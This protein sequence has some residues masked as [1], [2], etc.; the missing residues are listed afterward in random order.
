MLPWFEQPDL[1]LYLAPMAGFTDTVYRQL[2]KQEGADV[3]VSEFVLA[4]SLVRGT[5]EAWEEVAFTGDQRPFG[6]QI[7]GSS[8]KVMA[9]ATV[10]LSRKLRPDF[11][12]L[13]F[14]CPSDK[15]TCKDAGSS[16]LRNPSKLARV[17]TQVVQA[18][19]QEGLPVT[20]K[21]RIGW[22][23]Q[24]IVAL[25]VARRLEDAGVEAVAIHGRTKEQGYRGQA[26]WD[27][28]QEVAEAL[29]IP[30]IGNGNVNSAEQVSS[31]IRNSA[32]RGVMIGRAALGYPW[33]FREIK[34]TLRTGIPPQPPTLEER[35]QTILAYARLLLARPGRDRKQ[36]DI[37]WMRPRLIKLTKEMTGCKRVRGGLQEVTTLKELQ[38]LARQHLHRYRQADQAIREGMPRIQ[39]FG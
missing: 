33:I 34:A 17:A 3:L 31:I 39:A 15:V 24:S 37:R 30:V 16:L 2:C 8:P 29:T 11:I 4:D 23:G 12:D 7:F 19:K 18:G 26:N 21:I 14:G 5:P 28:I 20:A 36:G 22:D 25:E 32:I 1:P 6:T 38:A 9:E 35:W 13:N 27:I 10:Q